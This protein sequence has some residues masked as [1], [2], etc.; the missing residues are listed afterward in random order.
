VGVITN[1]TAVPELG[2]VGPEAAK[3]VQ[4][5][6]AVLFKRLADIDVFNLE[7]NTTDPERF[8]EAVR[9]LEPTFGA[10]NLRDIRALE[11]LRISDRLNQCMN[12]PVF[13]QNLYASAVVAAAALI[14]ALEIVGKR[15]EE[16]QV[17]IC[18]IG[19]GEWDAPGF[20]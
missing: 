14:N 8:I 16:I 4:E 9:L 19:S 2:N 10:V 11:G 1:G 7:L 20:C 13:N 15:T 18:G 6:L 12:I 5:G 3:P 17:V